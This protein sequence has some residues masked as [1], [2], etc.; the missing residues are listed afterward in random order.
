MALGSMV[1]TAELVREALLERGYSC[2]LVNARFAKPLDEEMLLRLE[3]KHKL[4]ATLEENVISGGFGE[5]V[6]EFYGSHFSKVHV[7]NIAIPDMYVEHGNVDILRRAA[8]IDEASATERLIAE[9][10]KLDR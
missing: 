2:T 6:T 8:E 10:Q 4:I 1:K 3:Q 7:V 5:H 9:Y